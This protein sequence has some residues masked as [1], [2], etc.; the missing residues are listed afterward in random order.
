VLTALSSQGDVNVLQN[1]R[2]S[3]LNNQ[4]AVFDVTTDEVFFAN[5]RQPIT[6]PNGGIIGFND[7]VTAQTISVGIV[8]DVLAQISA[9]NVLTMNI[10]PVVTSLDRIETFATSDGTSARFPV[11]SR[12]EGD[13]MALVRN[14]ETIIIGGLLQTQRTHNV[15]GVPIISRIP[16]VG[17]LFQ[18]IEDTERRVELVVFLTPTVITGQPGAGR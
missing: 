2:T 14:G 3:A 8:L 15:S 11:T 16:L 5:V 13:T 7:Q 18:H 1:A 17:K 6:G 4:R 9:D 10:R 12:R